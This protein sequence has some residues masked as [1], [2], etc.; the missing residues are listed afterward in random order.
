[1]GGNLSRNIASW[2]DDPNVTFFFFSFL[3]FSFL[4]WSFL[5]WSSQFGPIADI[6]LLGK[7]ILATEMWVCHTMFVLRDLPRQTLFWKKSNTWQ[8]VVNLVNLAVLTIWDAATSNNANESGPILDHWLQIITFWQQITASDSRLQHMTPQETCHLSSLVLQDMWEKEVS[9]AEEERAKVKGRVEKVQTNINE[10]GKRP[11][12]SVPFFATEQTSDKNEWVNN[13]GTSFVWLV[14]RD[15]NRNGT[16][17]FLCQ[18][19]MTSPTN[20]PAAEAIQRTPIWAP[21]SFML[22]FLITPWFGHYNTL[23]YALYIYIHT[24][25]LETMLILLILGYPRILL[26][27]C[28]LILGTPYLRWLFVDGLVEHFILSPAR[29]AKICSHHSV[30]QNALCT[31]LCISQIFLALKVKI[32]WDYKDPGVPSSE[33]L[34]ACIVSHQFHPSGLRPPNQ[35]QGAHLKRARPLRQKYLDRLPK[36]DRANG[37]LGRTYHIFFSKTWA[38][39]RL[40]HMVHP[41][42][43]GRERRNR[44]LTQVAKRGRT[45]KNEDCRPARVA[46]LKVVISQIGWC[47]RQHKTTVLVSHSKVI[48]WNFWHFDHLWP[49]AGHSNHGTKPFSR[50]NRRCPLEAELEL[51]GCDQICTDFRFWEDD[52]T[53]HGL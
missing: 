12:F 48:W 35:M 45:V 26:N 15:K 52:S 33:Y 36:A 22:P 49:I 28:M 43:R 17:L 1:M 11:N 50:W 18:N 8:T 13:L 20:C 38:L 4:F 40:Q 30:A 53:K 7:L 47:I 21:G 2:Q 51:H 41:S 37:L 23:W 24:F 29:P 6:R 3:F 39:P 5:F 10:A 25:E 27:Y 16:V 9:P 14:S 46:K 42:R 32:C 34:E 19:R 44:R 31:V